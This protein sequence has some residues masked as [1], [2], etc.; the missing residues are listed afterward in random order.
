M[1]PLG[2][3]HPSN[4]K[5]LSNT[6][7]ETDIASSSATPPP[8]TNLA[9]PTSQTG[10]KRN[11]P[12]HEQRTSDVKRKLKQYQTEM[13]AQAKLAILPSTM[14]AQSAS[15]P[16]SPRLLPAGSPGPI[17]PFELEES[18]GYLVAGSK[19]SLIAR[20]MERERGNEMVEEEG[21]FEGNMPPVTRA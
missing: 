11:R 9:I 5:S 15:T 13:I 19:V 1:M 2:K 21:R 3:Y 8:A 12:K 18:A 14:A 16:I 20:G 17:T 10:R 6:T 4:Y 7:P